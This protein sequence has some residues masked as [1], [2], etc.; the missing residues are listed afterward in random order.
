MAD[1]IYSPTT[2]FAQNAHANKSTYENMYAASI[3]DPDAFWAE[4]GQRLDWMTP[5]TK[6]KN[7]SFEHSNV[8]IK[9]YEDGEL[10]VRQLH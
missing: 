5:F 1:K 8:S 6:V 2:A 9:W 4:Q 7:T 3:T 10:N